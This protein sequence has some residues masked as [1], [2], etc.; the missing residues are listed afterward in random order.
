MRRALLVLAALWLAPVRPALAATPVAVD[1]LPVL[2]PGSSMSDGWTSF[3]VWLRNPGTSEV[4]GTLELRAKPVWSREQ[5]GTITSAPFALA[6]GA[7]VAVTL[8]THGF[9]STPAEFELH[10]VDGSKNVLSKTPAGE[11]RQNDPLL[12]DLSTPSRV[13]PGIR[14]LGLVLDNATAG[15]YRTPSA[16]VSTPPTDPATGDL[17]LPRWAAGYAG[18]TLV[19]ASG[20]RL[21]GI[22]AAEKKALADWVLAGGS[23]AVAIERPEDLRLEL[24]G[25]LA[26]GAPERSVP[27][28]E[29]LERA[30]FY[31]PGDPAPGVAS[32]GGG[33]TLLVE[34]LA[35]GAASAGL[36]EGFRG[37]NLRNSPWGSVASYG[38][39]ELHLLAFDLV[40]P[41]ASDRWTHLKLADLLRHA[42]ERRNAVALPLGRT[43]FDG[44]AANSVRAALDPNRSVRWTVIAAALL[45][46]IYAVLAGPL[47]FWLAARRGKPL[48]ALLHVPIWAA[49]TLAL[50]VVIG[51][52]GKGVKGRARRLTLIEAGAGM[53]RAAATRF[54][55][56]YASSSREIT[57]QPT[58]RASLV[59]VAT[60][61]DYVERKLLVDRDGQRL[62]RLRT[63]PWATVVVRDDG[64]A[65]LGGGVSIVREPDGRVAI[66][67]RAA[68]DLVAVVLKVPG[69]AALV[70]PRIRDG[71]VARERE[72]EPLPPAV[73]AL[74]YSSVHRLG[75]TLLAETLDKHGERLGESWSA[76][77]TQSGGDVDWWPDD[78]PVLIA[79]LD[80]GEGTTRD[81]GFDVDQ[82][83]VLVRV[84]GWG[85]VP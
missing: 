47:S 66:K 15:T 16:L 85:G 33:G 22:G 74:S 2:G 5:K 62:E 70:F 36:L 9:A 14:G 6:P 41:F 67:N 13:A 35:P 64:F 25:A 63:K 18:A 49:G 42:W 38:L 4:S 11:L 34:R 82:D 28:R 84:V 68:R 76:L 55:G 21:A 71:A 29:L 1:V 3:A 56:F 51:L 44:Y 50:I 60:G 17:V 26:G 53:E 39:G 59:E 81:S 20:K 83:R 54:R 77:E 52:I 69:Q 45:L 40:D 10:V 73:G 31:L 32:P 61:D 80:G 12:V 24:L 19:V 75:A 46:L 8:P 72:G 78:V 30:T 57:V 27:S 23:L 48:R 7:H 79:A 65:N 37:G 43:A 58:S